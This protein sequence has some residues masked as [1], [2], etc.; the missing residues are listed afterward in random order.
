MLRNIVFY[1]IVGALVVGALMVAGS[2]TWASNGTH[3]P[4]NGLVVGYLTQLIALT[5]VFIGVKT[6]R[7]NALGGVIKFFPA[8]GIGVAISAIASLGWVIGWEIVLAISGFDYGAVMVKTTIE[9]AQA[10]GAPEA[11]IQKLTAD[12][13]NFAQM[14]RNPLIRVPMTFVEMFPVGVLVSLISAALLRN[15]RFMP[16]RQVAA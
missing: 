10:R 9:Q 11:E 14:Y 1:G 6:H 7:D 8:L 2:L 16:A 4:E 12:M 13:T 3:P 15:S 5:V